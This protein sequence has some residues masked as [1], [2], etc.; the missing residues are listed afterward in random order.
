MHNGYRSVFIYARESSANLFWMD[1]DLL[2]VNHQTVMVTDQDGCGSKA[3]CDPAACPAIAAAVDSLFSGVSAEQAR[4]TSR[5]FGIQY[6]VIRLYDPAW[7]D[8]TNWV[9]TLVPVVSHDE[10]RDLGCRQ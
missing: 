1:I 9:S 8:K 4:A 10:F 2:G 3:G 7:K 5:Q 6:L